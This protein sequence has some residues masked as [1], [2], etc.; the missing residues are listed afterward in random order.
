[1]K[2]SRKSA[3]KEKAEHI[4]LLLL[5]L[6][7]RQP[8]RDSAVETQYI[9]EV[10]SVGGRKTRGS[11]QPEANVGWRRIPQSCGDFYSFFLNTHF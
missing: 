2:S 3:V 1:M 10:V 4:M 9:E 6:L 5:F 8:P 11:K 7:F